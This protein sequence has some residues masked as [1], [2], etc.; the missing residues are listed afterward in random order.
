MEKV[1]FLKRTSPPSDLIW[2][3]GIHDGGKWVNS[4]I[5][6]Q[7]AGVMKCGFQS[8]KRVESRCSC[9]VARRLWDHREAAMLRGEWQGLA[10]GVG[11]L[12][13]GRGEK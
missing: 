12:G 5:Y 1:C 10:N 6:V 7:R 2:T 11:W 13:L 3:V 4:I 9:G 8:S